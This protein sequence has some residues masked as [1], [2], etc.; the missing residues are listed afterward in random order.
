[1]RWYKLGAKFQIENIPITLFESG[2]GISTA[3]PAKHLIPEDVKISRLYNVSDEMIAGQKK[4]V[5]SDAFPHYGR[6]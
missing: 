5:M 3:N 6:K 1:M 4:R 2:N